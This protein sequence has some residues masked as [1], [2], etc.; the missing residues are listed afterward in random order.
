MVPL[1]SPIFIDF[2]TFS[3]SCFPSIYSSILSFSILLSSL[4]LFFHPLFFYS[5]ILSFSIFPSILSFSIFP[6][7]LSF[8]I[9]PS[10]YLSFYPRFIPLLLFLSQFGWICK[11]TAGEA[12]VTTSLRQLPSIF[13]I[14]L[15][16]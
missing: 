3:P 15:I 6:S 12:D 5:S 7:I 10:F 11:I 8:S 16:Q 14:L 13:T 2:F 4:F 9:L 1:S